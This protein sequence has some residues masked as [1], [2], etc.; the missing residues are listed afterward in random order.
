MITCRTVSEQATERQEGTLSA[1]NRFRH[2]VH[3]FVCPHCRRFDEQ[4]RTTRSLVHDLAK[5]DAP[6]PGDEYVKSLLAKRQ[7]PVAGR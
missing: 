1:W 7:P 3:L 5:D 2:R 6:P 4:L